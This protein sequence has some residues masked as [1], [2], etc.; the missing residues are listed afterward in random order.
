MNNLVLDRLMMLAVD[1]DA[2][3]QVRKF[4]YWDFLGPMLDA[5]GVCRGA[6]GQ[7]LVSMEIRSFPADAVVLATG[8][9]G[10]PPRTIKLRKP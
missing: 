9:C 1:A 5:N 7:D 6:I 3:G 8:G 2:D 4:E 10:L